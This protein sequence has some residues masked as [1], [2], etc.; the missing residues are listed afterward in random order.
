MKK[1]KITKECFGYCIVVLFIF[2]VIFMTLFNLIILIIYD[3]DVRVHIRN[4]E[5][6]SITVIAVEE[7]KTAIDNADE[8]GLRK[9]K[10]LVLD[11]KHVLD[12]YSFDS[13]YS[14]LEVVLSELRSLDE[15]TNREINQVE[16]NNLQR[17]LNEMEET[18]PYFMAILADLIIICTTVL[19]LAFIQ[20]RYEKAKK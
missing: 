14:N 7:L 15:N 3:L 10:A 1:I 5:K 8:F 19:P 20:D 16:L 6:A 17:K 2:P 12:I 11:K 13:Y 18:D 4:A 9:S